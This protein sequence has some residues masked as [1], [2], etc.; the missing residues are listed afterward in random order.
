MFFDTKESFKNA[1]IEAMQ[2]NFGKS[3][4]Q[5]TDVEKFLTLVGMIKAHANYNVYKTNK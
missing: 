1:Y 2:N 3:I 5:A 4:E